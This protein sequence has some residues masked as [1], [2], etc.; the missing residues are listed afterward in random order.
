MLSATATRVINRY[1]TN[2]ALDVVTFGDLVHAL[3]HEDCMH[4]V[5]TKLFYMYYNTDQY[6][7][8]KDIGKQNLPRVELV[9]ISRINEIFMN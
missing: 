1:I 6:F 4:G 5:V 8:C 2:Q 3:N 7:I 9:N